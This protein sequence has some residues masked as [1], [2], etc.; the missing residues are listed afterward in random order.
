M[1]K[2][3]KQYKKYME[4]MF[5]VNENYNQVMKKIDFNKEEN[6]M[7]RRNIF[8]FTSVAMAIVIAGAI[9]VNAIEPKVNAPKALIKVDVN[10]SVEMT[11]DQ[12]N[13]VVSITGKNDDGIM[14]LH[15]EKLTGKKLD[16]VLNVIIDLESEA[17]FLLKGEIEAT[18]NTIS[19][20][21]TGDTSELTNN[22]KTNIRESITSICDELNINES[23]N[24]LENYTRT[25]LENIVVE[26]DPTL[27]TSVSTLSIEE[28]LQIIANNQKELSKI[29][30]K[31]LQDLYI[32]AK[33]TEISF[34]E[35]E[36]FKNILGEV[37][38]TYQH[39]VSEYR[40]FVTSL[41][42]SKKLI[43]ETKYNLFIKSDS[44]YQVCLK[45]VLALKDE[46][47]LLN[48][49]IEDENTSAT[50]KLLAQIEIGAKTAL[51]ETAIVAL[52]NAKELANQTLLLAEEA[53]D[54]IIL[55]LKD[56]E[57][58]FPDEIKSKLNS[59]AQ[60]IENK[61]NKAKD[62]FFK[63]FEEKYQNDLVSAKADI[64]ARKQAL[65]SK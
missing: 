28:M 16:D 20:S 2:T 41:E 35:K 54:N 8:A 37:E 19:V 38:S 4:N 21:V 25:N 6:V 27:E 39:I 63:D 40:N 62:S 7:K 15:N 58:N 34:V 24:E 45:E 10:P 61:I 43:E 23:I 56:L 17:G 13:K 50:E 9:G 26:I 5:P 59:K 3:E 33:N 31:E 55:G 51:Y 42:S 29:Y 65:L 52:E 1:N 64:E 44:V 48:K 57:K 36:A 14:L 30:S 49:V 60:D 32:K 12:N 18:K 46:I 53:L 47:N 22:L 11:V